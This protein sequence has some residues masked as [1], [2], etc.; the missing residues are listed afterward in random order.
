MAEFVGLTFY[1]FWSFIW[2]P[3][4]SVS[5]RG[6]IACIIS[7][8]SQPF[9]IGSRVRDLLPT[10]DIKTSQCSALEL[11]LTTSP[12]TQQN[13]TA[14]E[15]K[16]IIN[17]GKQQKSFLITRLR[18]LQ[19]YFPSW[20]HI[21]NDDMLCLVQMS[22][23]SKGTQSIQF[24]ISHT[25]TQTVFISVYCFVICPRILGINL[26]SSG[27]IRVLDHMELLLATI[28]ELGPETGDTFLFFIGFILVLSLFPP[29][30]LALYQNE[31]TILINL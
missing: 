6:Y 3:C 4:L 2:I 24:Y 29:S 20:G 17:D 23:F 14:I 30:K 19:D 21:E 7:L 25:L 31:I 16:E 8:P 12:S 27:E 26:Q 13:S 15:R 11:T 22:I 5:V 28:W 10:L 18:N 1:C 9:S